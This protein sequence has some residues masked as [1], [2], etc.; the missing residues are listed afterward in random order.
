MEGGSR[1]MAK[2]HDLLDEILRDGASPRTLYLIFSRMKETGHLK[3]VIQECLKALRVY[4]HDLHLRR[5]LA[6]AYAEDGR[7]SQ[8]EAEIEGV[9]K[10]LA[11]LSSLFMLQAQVYK[12][13]GRGAEADEAL[14]RGLALRPGDLPALHTSMETETSLDDSGPESTPETGEATPSPPREEP[15]EALTKVGPGFVTPT[16]AEIYF[17]QGQVQEAVNTYEKVLEQ[18][19]QNPQASRRLQELKT[20]LDTG[21]VVEE[22][23][24]DAAHQKKAKVINTLETWLGHIRDIVPQS[25]AP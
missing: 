21:Q 16:L 23:A 3:R 25:T 18:E 20:L 22:R 7:W 8:A 5:V 9:V 12:E 17:N 2:P 19:P 15:E 6:E 11:E 14:K 13:Q 24:E 1:T 10:Q 4:P